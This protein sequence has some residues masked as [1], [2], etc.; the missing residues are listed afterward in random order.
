MK[1]LKPITDI[2]KFI[3]DDISSDI[4]VI[5]EIHTRIEN[6]KPII[7]PER[8]LQIKKELSQI[9]VYNFLKTNMLFFL[10]MSAAFLSGWWSAAN[11]YQDECNSFIIENY[12]EPYKAKG[13]SFNESNIFYNK[14]TLPI[15]NKT[16]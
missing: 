12:I 1:I 4:K 6:K 15:I 16:T 14:I 13:I 2:F 7:S 11:H 8:K 5:K 3:K 9:S 10:L